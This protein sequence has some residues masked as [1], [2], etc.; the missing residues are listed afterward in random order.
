MRNFSQVQDVVNNLS[1]AEGYSMVQ[2]IQTMKTLERQ[3]EQLKLEM[4]G[5]A[6]ALGDAGLMRQ[7]KAVV[8]VGK[9]VIGFF[10]GLDSSVQTFILTLGELAIAMGI[11][12]SFI[13]MMGGSA[14][15]A[16]AAAFMGPWG[17]P[18][19]IAAVRV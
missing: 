3:Y 9:D 1:E 16:K 18:V 12:K 14:V 2:N 5:L 19:A 6:Q 15:I 10:G 7:L 4:L 13:S 11:L 8:S 17:I